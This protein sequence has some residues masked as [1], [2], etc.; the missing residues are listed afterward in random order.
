M[1]LDLV[2]PIIDESWWKN[3]LAS[4][5]SRD[6]LYDLQ[7]NLRSGFGRRFGM[8]RSLLKYS[9]LMKF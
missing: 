3:N 9:D 7:K 4:K 8:S 1:P 2:G 5:K 6:A